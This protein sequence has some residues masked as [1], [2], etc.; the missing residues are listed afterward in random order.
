LA[1]L[2]VGRTEVDPLPVLL[3][4]GD[5]DFIRIE[6]AAE[7]Y[8]LIPGTKLAVLPDT[9]HMNII[10]RSAWLEPMIGERIAAAA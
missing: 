2:D 5:N 4:I 9:T 3:A 1:G 10:K 7:M 8:R 6:H